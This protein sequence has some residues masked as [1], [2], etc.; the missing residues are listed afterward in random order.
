[1]Q[2]MTENPFLIP[3]EAPYGAPMF[4]RID[5]SSYM[6]AFRE[7][8]ERTR[9][10]IDEIAG[11]S[12]PAT[13]SNTVEALEYSGMLLSEVENVFFNVLEA[14]SDETMRQIAE[15]V[16]PMLTD[17]SMYISMNQALF[18]RVKAVYD[19]R[20]T[21]VL[22][23]D[24]ARLLEDTYRDF[25]R[26]G[27]GLEGKSK[28]RFAQVNRQLSLLELKFGN[29][30]LA[31]T[32]AWFLHLT[33]EDELEGL[34]QYV[35][36]MGK[37]S[38]AEKGVEGWA[39]TLD[40]PSCFP[41][42]KFS[43]RR[44]LRKEIYIKYN[45]RSVG[46]EFDN[47]GI[48]RE[49]AA[50]RAEKASLL[51]YATY[52]DY[53]LENRM[54]KTAPAVMSFLDSLMEPTLPVARQ[55]Q[56]R[57]YEYAV[58]CGFDDD[59]LKGWDFMFWAE[60]Y[61]QEHYSLGEELIKPY[62]RL[63]SVVDAVLGL[64]TRL[65]G[66]RFEKRTDIPVYHKD[67]VVYDVLDS[68]GEHLSLLYMDFFP[69]PSK[70][71][72]AWMTEFRGQYMQ[73]GKDYRPFISI[74][75]NF[76]KPT[77]DAPSLLTHNEL[78]TI[79]H[80]FG[81]ALHG[82]LSKGRY[83]SQCGTNVARDFVEFPSQIMENWAFEPEYLSSF[84]KHYRTGEPLPEEYIERIVA[85]KNYLAASQQVRQLRFG[86]IDM[87]WHTLA[88]NVDKPLSEEDSIE[89]EKRVLAPY[90][91]L[92]YAEGTAI[93]P[94]FGHIFSG[95]YS[96]GYYSYKWAEV[97]EADGFSLFREKGIFNREVSARLRSEVLEKG[98]TADE[99]LLYRNFRGHNP[100][101]QALLRKLGIIK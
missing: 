19:R 36:D 74:V 21:L 101:P 12:A 52:A 14:D 86:Y 17:L 29:N 22:A 33:S 71:G 83:P 81:H 39:F 48:I 72:G 57:I 96:A 37:A 13:F 94:S 91:T 90:R 75:T 61:Q 67:V 4:D 70:R 15:E 3:S 34:P 63:D 65:Y 89:F 69:R 16:S 84:A 5:N 80:E 18:C 60:K 30:V 8:V 77:A 55:E 6:P 51:G 25:V 35:I 20:D 88:F 1:M 76:S 58:S 7:A 42:L 82:M 41:F 78:T 73:D 85:A 26:G 47:T 97:L 79:L 50:L 66:L 10:E 54:A 27:A 46:G 49:I 95:G 64:A 100:E 44:D 38:A 28:E 92:P 99:A 11:N 9:K 98:S 93:C 40:R 53:A 24:Q 87:A 31:S 56:A 62:F 68:E 59:C 45:S 2:P 23:Q 32:N 43:E